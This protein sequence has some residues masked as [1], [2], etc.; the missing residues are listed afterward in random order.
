VKEKLVNAALLIASIVFSFLVLEVSVRTYKGHWAYINLRDP[1][2]ANPIKEGYPTEFDAELGW[3]PK[4]STRAND[5]FWKSWGTTVTILAD[6]IRSNGH[7][8]VRDAT[9][10]ILAVGDSFTFGDEVSDWETWPAQLEELSGKRVINGGVSGYGIDQAFLRARGLLNRYR[11][12][13]AIL[14]FIPEDIHRCQMS[15]MWGAAKP[16]FDFND[17]RLTL[18]TVPIPPAWPPSKDSDLLVVLEHS[19]LVQ[20]VMKRMFPNWWLSRSIQV[21]DAEKGVEVACAVLHE[22]EKLTNSRGSRLIVLVEH[23]DDEISFRPMAAEG[24]VKGALSCL[25]DPA[26]RVLDL[27]P[28]LYELKAEHPSRYNEL[29]I[30]PQRWAHMTAKGNRFVALEILKLLTQR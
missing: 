17:G 12:S 4:P 20:S 2:P 27:R 26:T 28:A 21:Q 24:D 13:T 25:S 7:S 23:V 9:N 15:V 16:Y 19:E 10:P 14:S 18:E 30:P 29:Y 22:L 11:F 6:G 3:V 8:E 1:L 5:T